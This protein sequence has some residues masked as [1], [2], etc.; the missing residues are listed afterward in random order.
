MTSISK[1]ASLFLLLTFG[2]VAPI[3]AQDSLATDT[4]SE[5]YQRTPDTFTIESYAADSDFQYQGAPRNPDSFRD[6]FINQVIR[7]LNFIFGNPIGNFFLR[8]VLYAT[9]AFL[10]LVLINQLIGGNLIN[11]F[12]KKN[13]GPSF[14]LNIGEEELESLDLEALLDSSLSKSDFPAATRYLYLITLKM[15]NEH[16]LISWGI[17]K[18]NIDY[19]REFSSHSGSSVFISL[20]SYYEFVEYG[21]FEIDKVGYEL[22]DDLYND[23]KN[24]VES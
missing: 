19:E 23:L 24:R 10:V 14:S 9:I 15:L 12:N 13:S 7:F 5:L 18:T 3:L 20:T 2:I 6:R 22:V 1:I 4:D 17:E 11:V 16:N 21:D 8:L